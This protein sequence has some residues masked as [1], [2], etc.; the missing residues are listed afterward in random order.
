MHW[1]LWFVLITAVYLLVWQFVIFA[2]RRNIPYDTR[3][4]IPV[5]RKFNA[6]IARLIWLIHGKPTNFAITLPHPFRRKAIINYARHF[7][8]REHDRHENCHVPI[9]ERLGPIPYLLTAGKEAEAVEREPHV[10]LTD[11]VAIGTPPSA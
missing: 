6:P 5:A 3:S 8:Q 7:C 4:S 1:S 11:F 10:A 2:P 9:L